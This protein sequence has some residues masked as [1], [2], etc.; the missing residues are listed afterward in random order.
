MARKLNDYEVQLLFTDNPDLY[1]RTVAHD[2]FVSRFGWDQVSWATVD[3]MPI[4][5]RGYTVTDPQLGTVIV[6]PDSSGTLHYI[7]TTTPQEQSVAGTIMQPSYES[8][9]GFV[10]GLLDQLNAMV[11]AS[12]GVGGQ[13]LTALIVVGAVL[14]F[15][16][17]K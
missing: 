16:K 17:L 1:Q 2:D 5:V 13:I 15:T 4:P 12:E 7:A 11:A 9:D 6:F 8:P 14:L 3:T 10:Q